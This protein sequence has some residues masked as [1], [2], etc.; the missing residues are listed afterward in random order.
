M[1]ALTVTEAQQRLPEL[2][3]AARLGEPVVI[4]QQDRRFQLVALP[5]PPPRPRPPITGT[6]KAGRYEGRLVVPAEFDEPIDD[7]REY[8]P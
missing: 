8:I 5:F 1:D 2:L 6:P 7:L 4:V 3:D